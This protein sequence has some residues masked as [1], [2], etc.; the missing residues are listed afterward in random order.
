MMRSLAS[1]CTFAVVVMAMPAFAQDGGALYSQHCASCHG[2]GQVTRAPSRDVIAALAPE[3]IVAALET[4]TMRV[5]GETLTAEQ[6]RAIAAYSR[7]PAGSRR[8]GERG[9]RRAAM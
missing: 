4:G 3:R 1:G 2:G 6:R 5:Q 7:R 9:R 8:G